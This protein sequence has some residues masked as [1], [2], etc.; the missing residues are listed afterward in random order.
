MAIHSAKCLLF[1]AVVGSGGSSLIVTGI[2]R[3]ETVGSI[4][5]VANAGPE[6]LVVGTGTPSPAGTLRNREM[7]VAES[8]DGSDDADEEAEEDVEAMVAEV[9][10][11]GTRDENGAEERKDADA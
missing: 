10:P 2:A 8:K 6:S 1:V 5:E 7:I 9:E 11:A 4:A 3:P